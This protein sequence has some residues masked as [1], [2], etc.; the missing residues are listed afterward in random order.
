MTKPNLFIQFTKSIWHDGDSALVAALCRA[1][2]SNS[3]LPHP[4]GDEVSGPFVALR[5]PRF[6]P[7]LESKL[8]CSMSVWA[9]DTFDF[10]STSSP[11]DNLLLNCRDTQF[12][13]T[14]DR[15]NR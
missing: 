4:R 6:T 13:L 3:W 14:P 1:S 12:N 15:N 11:P 10:R 7:A 9:Y 8:R 2:G 5:V